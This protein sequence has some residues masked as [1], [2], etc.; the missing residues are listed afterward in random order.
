MDYL[1]GAGGFFGGGHLDKTCYLPQPTGI[2]FHPRLVLHFIPG[3]LYNGTGI[4]HA[5]H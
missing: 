4:P 5:D 2:L 3:K 1:E